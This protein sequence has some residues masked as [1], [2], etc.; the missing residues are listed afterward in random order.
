MKKLLNEEQNLCSLCPRECN[1]DR[2][3]NFGF[4]KSN[5]LRIAR[6][7]LHEWEEPCISGSRGSGTIFFSGCSLRCEYCQNYDVS[8]KSKGFDI[9]ASKLVDIF[10]ELEDM[11]AENINLVTPTHFADKIIEALDKYKPNIPVCYNTSSYEKIETLQ[12]LK[13]Y[14]DIYLADY[15][16]FDANLAKMLSRTEDYPKV[17]S[18]AILQ[19]RKNQPVDIYNQ[20]GIMQKGLIVRHLVLPNCLQNS[21][22]VLKWVADNLGEKTKVS[23]MSQYTPFGKAL[24]NELINRKLKP[25]EY[26]II[27][28][29]ALKIGLNNAYVQECDSSSEAYIPNFVGENLL[30]E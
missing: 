24:Q 3:K 13:D 14:V 2:S 5:G 8:Q 15:K 11:G 16:Y 17:A 1:V 4:C 30:E 7:G 20:E 29:Y 9:N 23:I 6:Y 21:K 12:K 25:I 26:K 27:V 18:D 28:N 10:K 19:M 22:D